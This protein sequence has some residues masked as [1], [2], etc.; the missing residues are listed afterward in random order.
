MQ[1]DELATLMLEPDKNFEKLKY[2]FDN[3]KKYRVIN[4]PLL[5]DEDHIELL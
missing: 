3:N 1:L 2:I 4:S 5:N